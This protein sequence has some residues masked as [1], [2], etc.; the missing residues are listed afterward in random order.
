[1]PVVA[2]LYD[3][4]LFIETRDPT[5]KALR[6][7]FRSKQARRKW[8]RRSLNTEDIEAAKEKAKALFNTYHARIE[9]GLPSNLERTFGD[10]C[11]A[12]KKKLLQLRENRLDKPTHRAYFTIIDNWLIPA[13]GNKAISQIDDAAVAEFE[14]DRALR[15]K[16]EPPKSTINHHN[17]VLRAVMEYAAI[18]KYINRSQIPKLSVKDKGKRPKRRPRF[19]SEE[20]V[21]LLD[22]LR[23]WELEGKTSATV[24]KRQLLRCYVEF[25]YFTGCRPGNEVDLLR[26]KSIERTDTKIKVRFDHTKN[27][28][29]RRRITADHRLHVTLER[30]EILT[31]PIAPDLY[32]FRMFGGRPA[33]G[34]SELFSS[35]L[36]EAGLRLTDFGEP[37]TL[38]SIRHSFASEKII[39]GIV[40]RE[41]LAQ[42]MGT[43]WQML[44][45]Y[46]VELH[47]ELYAEEF[48]GGDID[49]FD[50][51]DFVEE[52]KGVI[53]RD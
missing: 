2:K 36:T 48:S 28:K 47:D 9:A 34:F 32:L 21:Q 31:H 35:A 15:Y 37:R 39:Q 4:E 30:L 27:E 49:I 52:L 50:A 38:Y 14:G 42:H 13:F 16:G 18:K 3:D 20:M 1:M 5:T 6:A 43:S 41:K 25:L 12:Y 11:E 53:G 44:E 33:T 51:G 23:L 19:S 40:G 8:E 17:V 22:F 24:F 26:W 29:H 7:R 10:V 45:Q 46:Y